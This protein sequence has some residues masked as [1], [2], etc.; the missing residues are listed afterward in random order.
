MGIPIWN[1]L[2]ALTISDNAPFFWDEDDDFMHDFLEDI[3]SLNLNNLKTIK[4]EPYIDPTNILSNK[5]SLE[6]VT[7]S[8]DYWNV[9]LPKGL[10]G[11][12]V[13]N[14]HTS[15]DIPRNIESLHLYDYGSVHDQDIKF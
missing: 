9:D 13:R 12:A 10:R 7:L 2:E 1:N 14:D 15:S 8:C 6:F 11:F 3:E 4:I 5:L